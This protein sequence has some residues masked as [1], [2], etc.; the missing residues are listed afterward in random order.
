MTRADIQQL[1]PDTFSFFQWCEPTHPFWQSV[2]DIP[3]QSAQKGHTLLHDLEQMFAWLRSIDGNRT[4][5]DRLAV[6]RTREELLEELTKWYVAYIYREHGA[7]VSHSGQGY[8]LELEIADQLLAMGVVQF[9]NFKSLHEQFADEVEADK[10]FMNDAEDTTGSEEPKD[11]WTNELMDLLE[12]SASQLDPH[13]TA[14]H[15]VIAVVTPHTHLPSEYVLS[16][17][18]Q[19]AR[20]EMEERFPH[21]SGI[22]LIDP[23]PGSE[24]ATFIGF[25]DDQHE[26]EQLLNKIL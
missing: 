9:R 13:P 15:Q 8:D 17:T 6:I 14:T 26:L 10:R 16:D 23:R 19:S 24:R 12:E 22:V 20:A 3:M 5:H 11:L 25:H 4:L 7:R 21:I 2:F 18:I 1:Y